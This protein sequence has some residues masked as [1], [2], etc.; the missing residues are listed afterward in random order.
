MLRLSQDQ[1]AQI[2]RLVLT[3]T[4]LERGIKTTLQIAI[5][6][7]EGEEKM[8]EYFSKKRFLGAM[9]TT[10]ADVIP[11]LL[12]VDDHKSFFQLIDDM[13]STVGKRNII[14]HGEWDFS[15]LPL[16]FEESFEKLAHQYA[17]VTK[18][19]ETVRIEEIPQILDELFGLYDRLMSYYPSAFGVEKP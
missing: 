4:L 11:L 14:T 15:R 7:T 1:F 8:N 10:L 5:A 13:R 3:A 17:Y 2:G 9:I 12:A 6:I 16:I 18:D 19:N